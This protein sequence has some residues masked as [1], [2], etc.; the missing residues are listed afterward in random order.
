MGLWCCYS[1]GLGYMGLGCAEMRYVRLGYITLQYM[2][3]VH[4]VRLR[5]GY[6]IK[7]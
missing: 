7:C 4:G 1:I 3:S 6:S 2:I 5:F